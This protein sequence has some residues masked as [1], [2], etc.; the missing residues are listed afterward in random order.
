MVHFQKKKKEILTC[1][2]TG[3]LQRYYAKEN[4]SVIKRLILCG[5]TYMR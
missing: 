3:E 2:N 4:K 5:F 1:Y